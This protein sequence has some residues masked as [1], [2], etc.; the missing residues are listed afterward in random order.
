M[1][2]EHHLAA[3][4]AAGKV[5]VVLARLGLIGPSIQGGGVTVSGGGSTSGNGSGGGV[6]VSLNPH[7]SDRRDWLSLLLCAVHVTGASPAGLTAKG[8]SVAVLPADVAAA[9]LVT[10]AVRG[11]APAAPHA[12]VGCGIQDAEMQNYGSQPAQGSTAHH[13]AEV[14]HLDAAAFGI[15]PRPI[16]SLLDDVERA[17]GSAALPLQREL[18]YLAWRHRVAAAGAPASL[19]LAM[20]P[21]PAGRGGA[22]RLPSGARRRLR[23]IRSSQRVMAT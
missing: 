18:P 2:A 9:A 8:R 1:V 4:A 11:V 16:S 15:S 6:G 20:L 10:H 17:R 21:P 5:R 23:E 3:A 7:I 22:L 19:A 14:I 12:D 13:A